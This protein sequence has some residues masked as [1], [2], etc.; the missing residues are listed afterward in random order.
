[1]NGRPKFFAAAVMLAILAAPSAARAAQAPDPSAGVTNAAPDA[2][3]PATFSPKARK[4]RALDADNHNILL[5]RPG[6]ITVIVG[7]NE[8]TQDAARE[9]GRAMYPFEGRSDFQ[10]IVVVDLRGS[11]ANWV[12]SVV[13]NR[14]RA[15]LDAEAVE[16]KPFFVKNGDKT[17]PRP[18]LH[19]VPDFTG[20]ICPQLGWP[21]GSDDLRVLICGVDGREIVRLD[22]VDDMSVLQEAVRK[23][24]Q[25]QVTL[26][27]A[28]LAEDAKT[29]GSK[30]LHIVMQHPPLAPYTPYSPKKD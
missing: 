17:N 29:P 30:P 6:V 26:E 27:Q 22:K 9:A 21:E 2:L 25:A 20:T 12:P 10:L 13:T 8:D 15:S 3:P 11:I 16:L 14:M 7:T 19:V 18:A 1:M 23:A 4:F 28:R 5:N 24:I